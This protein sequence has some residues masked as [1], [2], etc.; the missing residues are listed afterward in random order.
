MTDNT[1][2]TIT[3]ND[4]CVMP[5]FTLGTPDLE[6]EYASIKP[7]IKEFIKL[8]FRSIDTA[9]YY[10]SEPYIGEALKE[11]FEE[12]VV[13]REELFITTKV[14]PALW[15]RAETSVKKS[16][17]DLGLD[18]VDLVLH[19]WPACF[20]GTDAEGLPKIPKDEKGAVKIDH[21]ADWLDTYKQLIKIKEKG[22]A[23]SI[24]VSNY[25]EK[26]LQRAIDET[27]VTPAMLQMELHPKLPQLE[28][29]KFAESK[30]IK[31]AAFSPLGSG[32][33]PLLKE[34]VVLKIAE[35]YGIPPAFICYAYHTNRG[36]VSITRTTKVERVKDMKSVKLP[37]LTAEELEELDQVGIKDP[38]RYIQDDWGV[39]IG[40]E[41]FKTKPSWE[42]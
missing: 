34:P 4:G 41:Y 9:W 5:Q 42:E 10:G 28:L 23:K 22:L 8:G 20:Y 19:H 21:N 16:L 1:K 29:V 13:K 33:V 39:V 26:Y 3:L 36:R 14:W 31:V 18:Y 35:K 40:F 17:S 12:G 25:N 11:L 27:G 15:D 24:G 32:G 38:K 30:G 7:V 2:L 6:Y 37:N